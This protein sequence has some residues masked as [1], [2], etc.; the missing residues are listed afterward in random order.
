MSVLKRLDLVVLSKDSDTD[1]KTLYTK[2][3]GAAS[4]NISTPVNFNLAELNTVS[5]EEVQLQLV[6]T[7]LLD[8]TT[9]GETMSF[10]IGSADKALEAQLATRLKAARFSHRDA[11]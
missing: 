7:D 9:R 5:G 2:G 6:A 10:T 1:L 4:R 3:A 11:D 8:Q